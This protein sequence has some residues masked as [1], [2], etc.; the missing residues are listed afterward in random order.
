MAAASRTDF[1][2]DNGTYTTIDDPF[3]IE[4]TTLAAI[5]ASG[6]AAGTY[7]DSSGNVHGF[8][9]AR[10]VSV[11]KLV[12]FELGQVSYTDFIGI[13]VLPCG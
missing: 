6:E 10:L 13:T 9:Y 8:V 11:A 5:N 4:G 3:G 12:D 1:I 2:Y 7:T